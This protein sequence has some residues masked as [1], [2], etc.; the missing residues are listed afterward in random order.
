MPN[1]QCRMTNKK[2]DRPRIARMTRIFLN[3]ECLLCVLKQCLILGHHFAVVHLGLGKD[4]LWRQ[5]QGQ[6]AKPHHGL[7]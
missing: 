5:V 2:Y 1:D 6:P 4:G 3:R 7:D